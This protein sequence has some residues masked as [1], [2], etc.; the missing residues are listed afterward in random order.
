MMDPNELEAS[1]TEPSAAGDAA[2]QVLSV[3]PG[4]KT[5]DPED[6]A[7]G[8]IVLG[9]LGVLVLAKRNLSR[10]SAGHLHISGMDAV[11]TLAT[12]VI[13]LAGLKTLAEHYDEKT[14][15]KALAWIVG[16]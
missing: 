13:G 8:L 4:G 1:S 2:I 16:A 12:V 3:I 10:Q 14:W 15:A 7:A 6:V 11:V 5:P 9:A